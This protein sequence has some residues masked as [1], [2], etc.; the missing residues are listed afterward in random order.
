MDQD[1]FSHPTVLLTQEILY[2][3]V[4][5]ETLAQFRSSRGA[6]ETTE[7]VRVVGDVLECMLTR[8]LP[9]LRA[10]RV[11]H[12][13]L[14]TENLLVEPPMDS[15]DATKVWIID[16]EFAVYH[17]DGLFDLP[18]IACL[19][20]HDPSVGIS[21]DFQEDADLIFFLLCMWFQFDRRTYKV[22]SFAIA[23]AFQAVCGVPMEWF[24][25]RMETHCPWARDKSKGI[26]GPGWNMF[27][28]LSGELGRRMKVDR[29]TFV[30]THGQGPFLSPF[31]PL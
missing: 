29:C 15:D 10:H 28:R 31:P 18:R 13:D 4:R 27:F 26:V 5:G 25:E 22:C 7:V 16:A 19:Q 6:V 11:N 12:W 1:G 2:P 17:M 30:E 24:V 21:M 3:K 14:K 9:C 23:S 20:C 8:I